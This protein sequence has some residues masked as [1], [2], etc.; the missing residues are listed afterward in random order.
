MQLNLKMELDTKLSI[1]QLSA[2]FNRDLFESLNPKFA[3][4][5]V[6]KFDGCKKNDRYQLNFLFQKWEGEIIFTNT[7]NDLFEFIDEARTLPFPFRYWRHHHKVECR[8][9]KVFLLD[10]IYYQLSVP[11][12]DR[13]VKY[14][15][16]YVF[17]KRWPVYQRELK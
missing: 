10:H 4:V 13:P 9:G 7:Q 14:V 11:L 17:K 15:L 3:P 2:L 1:H 12:L 16:N 8:E 6:L 5:K